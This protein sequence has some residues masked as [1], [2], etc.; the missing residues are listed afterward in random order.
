MLAPLE[1]DGRARMHILQLEKA[2][3]LVFGRSLVVREVRR[4]QHEPS[5]FPGLY[6]R[7]YSHQICFGYML[8]RRRNDAPCAVHPSSTGSQRGDRSRLQ[9]VG[10]RLYA[11]HRCLLRRLQ[12]PRPHTVAQ[13]WRRAAVAQSQTQRVQ[14]NPNPIRCQ[15]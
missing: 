3:Q 1:H 4:T 8:D 10:Y 12:S 14:D 15:R 13:R 9:H 6:G 11:M 7:P 2:V 5:P